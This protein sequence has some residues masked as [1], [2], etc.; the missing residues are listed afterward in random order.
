HGKTY[1]Y[2]VR[3]LGWAGSASEPSTVEV[4]TPAELKRPPTP[5]APDVHLTDLK[6]LVAQNDWGKLGVNKSIEGKP[7]TIEGRRYER[8]LGCHAKSLLV[9]KIPAGAK[10]FVAVVGLDDEK[11]NDPRSSVTFEVH[12]DV[13]EMGEAPVMLAKTPV[14][15]SKT[16]R[17]W[18]FNV[19][20]NA[21]I[22]ELRL[23]VTDAGD[24][25]AADHADWVDAGFVTK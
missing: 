22:K 4:A 6:P 20:L 14:L 10:R 2:A 17:S 25:I 16:I 3:A 21:R 18:A 24:G 5:P 8:G 12:G 9:Y 7:L 1:R 13:K 11:K 19:E 23:V 15:S